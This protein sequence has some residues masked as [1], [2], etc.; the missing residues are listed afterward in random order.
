M[1]HG[2]KEP[3][4]MDDPHATHAMESP[5]KLSNDYDTVIDFKAFA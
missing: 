3:E 5:E 1:L 2:E 4:L